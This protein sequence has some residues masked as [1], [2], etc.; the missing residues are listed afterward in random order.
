MGPDGEPAGL[1]DVGGKAAEQAARIAGVLAIVVN[2]NATSIG[3]GLIADAIAVT[4]WQLGEAL[5]LHGAARTDP[6]LRRAKGLL[7]WLAARRLLEADEALRVLVDHRWLLE[8]CE[9]PRKWRLVQ[10]GRNAAGVPA[11]VSFGSP[12]PGSPWFRAPGGVRR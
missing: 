11:R 3:E 12:L 8:V 2:P 6:R 7:D 5:R 10:E 4:D 1:R 9:R